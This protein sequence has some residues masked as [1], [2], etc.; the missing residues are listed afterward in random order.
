M[1]R[2]DKTTE[3]TTGQ[4]YSHHWFHQRNYLGGGDGRVVDVA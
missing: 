2:H 3:T 4:A 1:P